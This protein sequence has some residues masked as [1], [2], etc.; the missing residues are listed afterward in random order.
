MLGLEASMDSESTIFESHTYYN[1]LLEVNTVDS[2]WWP[3]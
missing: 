2:V 1:V 3:T